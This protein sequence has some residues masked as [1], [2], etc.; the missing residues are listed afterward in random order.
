MSINSSSS[1]LNCLARSRSFDLLL[2]GTSDSRETVGGVVVSG[3]TFG[4]EAPARSK[5]VK[6]A[7]VINPKQNLLGTYRICGR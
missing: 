4:A 1:G 7:S 3:S 5:L 6:D 2:S